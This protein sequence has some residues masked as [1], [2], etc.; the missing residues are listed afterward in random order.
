MNEIVALE[1]FPKDR[2]M[3]FDDFGAAILALLSKDIDGVV[4]DNVS[5]SGYMKENEGKLKIGGQLTSDEKLAFVFPPKSTLRAAV[6]AALQAMMADGT[7]DALNKKW[8]LSQ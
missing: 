2:V 4:I 8:A 5:A 1:H 7:L 3:S 6:D